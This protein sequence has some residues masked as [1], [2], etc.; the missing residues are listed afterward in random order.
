MVV[1]EFGF[2]VGARVRVVELGCVGTVRAISISGKGV[3][4][5]VRYSGANEFL[6]VWFFESELVV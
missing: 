1:K 4:Y 5:L 2:D 3:E 6:E